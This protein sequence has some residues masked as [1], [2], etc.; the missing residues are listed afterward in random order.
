VLAQV[1]T[2]LPGLVRRKGELSGSANV[3]MLQAIGTEPIDTFD[4]MSPT[5]RLPADQSLVKTFADDG[6]SDADDLGTGSVNWVSKANLGAVNW[7]EGTAECDNWEFFTARGGH[8]D[9]A[10]AP[11]V[12]TQGLCAEAG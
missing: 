5:L 10:P 3:P 1:A 8:A 7:Q 6:I 4:D 12:L 11:V 9:A 2:G